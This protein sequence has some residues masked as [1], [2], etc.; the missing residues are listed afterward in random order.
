MASPA[1]PCECSP[2]SNLCCCGSQNGITVVQPQCQTLPNGSVV[3]NPAF[4]VGLN[5]SFWTY[6]F[7]T[8]CDT[9]TRGISGIGIPICAEIN[10]QNITVEEKI[11]G[12]GS[13]TVVPFELIID[14][15]NFGLAPE[16]FQF[17]KIITDDRYDK[18]VC[19]QYR[20]AIIG[21]Y[22]EEVQAISVKAGNPVYKFE[23]ENCFIVPGCVPE[24]KL[25]VSKNSETVIKNNQANI[26]Y[27]V[28]VD[29]IGEALLDPVQFEDLIEIPTQLS[30][31][32]IVVSPSSLS[33][34][35]SVRGRILISGDLGEIKPG[36]RVEI[37]YSIPIIG[38]SSPASYIISNVARAAAEGTESSDISESTLDVVKLSATKCASTN[39]NIGTFKFVIASVGDSP[40]VTVDILD[41]MILPTGVRVQFENFNGCE[42]YYAGTQTPIPLNVHLEGPISIDIICRNATIHSFESFTK[43]IS[44][45]LVSSSTYGTSSI[46]NGI[47]NVSPLNVEK[48]IYEGTENLPATASINVEIAQ[49]SQTPC[50]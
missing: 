5:S 34:D 49:A 2:Y 41:Q 9:E 36:E 46:I 11:D 30:L 42:A 28:N 20:I 15:P 44:Y 33:V 35:T 13:Y 45:T 50:Q 24:G 7:I 22:P 10:A 6:K 43:T 12:C 29:N 47:T 21:D 40:D 38:I 1:Q 37:S 39:G 18:G 27:K 26:E 3:N 17:L 16:G 8:N 31:G 32:Q 19:T 25:L 23:C 48:M 14:D 4:V